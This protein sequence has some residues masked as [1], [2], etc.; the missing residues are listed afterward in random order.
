MHKTTAERGNSFLW[1][2]RDRKDVHK[3]LITRKQLQANI[4]WARDR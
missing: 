1:T 2:K 3:K 4:K